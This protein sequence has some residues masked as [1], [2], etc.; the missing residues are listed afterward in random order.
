M[1]LKYVSQIVHK[2]S[3]C[4]NKSVILSSD[5]LL[6]VDDLINVYFL[7]QTTKNGYIDKRHKSGVEKVVTGNAG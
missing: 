7:F 5:W 2:S 4:K 6:L 3:M 1:L